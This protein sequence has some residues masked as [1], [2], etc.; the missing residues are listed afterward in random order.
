MT[1]IFISYRRAASAYQA[2]RL[3]DRLSKAF[4]AQNAFMDVDDIPAGETFESYILTQIE[5]SDVFLAM[6]A[7]G[8]LDRIHN[9]DDWVRRE[10]AYA[11]NLP[12]VRVIPVLVDGFGMPEPAD[13]PEDIRALTGRNAEL[14]IHSLFDETSGRIIRR[15]REGTQI[16]KRPRRSRNWP[17]IG[18]VALISLIVVGVLASTIINEGRGGQPTQSV[19]LATGTAATTTQDAFVPTLTTAP[20][21]VPIPTAAPT[22]TITPT[23]TLGPSPTGTM[24]P[25]ATDTTPPT[26]TSTPTHTATPTNTLPPTTT[27]TARPSL[28]PTPTATFS[29]TATLVPLGSSLANPILHNTDWTPNLLQ[30]VDGQKVV[31]V[32]SGC[33]MM[34]SD[35]GDLD[36]QPVNRQCFDTPFWISQ[37][38]VTNREYKQCVDAGACTLPHNTTYYNSPTYARFPVTFVDWNQA[39]DYALWREGRLPTEAEWEYAA[40]GPDSWIYPW[41]NEFDGTHLNFCDS[42]CFPATTGRDDTVSDGYGTIGLVGNYPSNASWVGALDMSGNVDEWVSSIYQPYPYDSGD[43]REGVGSEYSGR[44]L[45]GGAWISDRNETRASSRLSSGSTSTSL[46]SGFRIVLPSVN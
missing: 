44:I 23:Q 31:L 13:L 28:T 1:R 43:G 14:L 35:D 37:Y 26:F 25:T 11:L 40:R 34:G 24:L 39:N 10:I 22:E 32:P 33:F 7:K 29:L 46:E 4:G 19:A 16:Q 20:T 15:I 2:G 6:L 3:N 8:T 30:T 5:Q 12:N 18:I 45:R 38:E 36:E 21:E 9:P 27:P 42:H 41:G 17:V